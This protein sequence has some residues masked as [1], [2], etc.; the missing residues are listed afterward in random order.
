MSNFKTYEL[1]PNNEKLRLL[2]MR[3][4]YLIYKIISTDLRWF[5][6]EDKVFDLRNV[7]DF[8][9]F[10]MILKGKTSKMPIRVKSVVDTFIEHGVGK[11][12]NLK[13]VYYNDEAMHIYTPD[14][15]T[16]LGK[17]YVIEPVVQISD[18]L[19][20]AEM[21]SLGNLDAITIS[22]LSSFKPY[23]TLRDGFVSI[24]GLPNGIEL[25]EKSEEEARLI[26]T[27]R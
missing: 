1:I 27:L 17:N 11:V 23:F 2:R 8:Y 15:P 25:I 4:E 22:D 10:S 20:N 24:P 5:Y 12:D 9:E 16:K 26:K 6:N 18:T 7:E 3:E 14:F 13:T 21:L 19:Y